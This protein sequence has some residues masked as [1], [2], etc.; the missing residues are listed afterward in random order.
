MEKQRRW[1]DKSVGIDRLAFQEGTQF[2]AGADK[3]TRQSPASC[4]CRL[5]LESGPLL[6]EGYKVELHRHV[7]LSATHLSPWSSPVVPLKGHGT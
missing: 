2:Y 4:L 6:A 3:E 5:S 1:V 7:V